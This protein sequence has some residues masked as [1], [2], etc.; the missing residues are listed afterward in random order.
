MPEIYDNKKLKLSQGLQEMMPY[1]KRIDI[2]T[3]YIDL[4]GWEEIREQIDRA[5]F[6]DIRRKPN[7]S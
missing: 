5:D 3:G 4:R 2:A 7:R 1:Y 6:D